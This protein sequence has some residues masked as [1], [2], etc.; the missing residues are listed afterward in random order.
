MDDSYLAD[1]LMDGFKGYQLYTEEE[2]WDELDNLVS[3][4]TEIPAY[5]YNI[6][7]KRENLNKIKEVLKDEEE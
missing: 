6:Y 2:L 3:N 4:G 7:I 5:I 1:L